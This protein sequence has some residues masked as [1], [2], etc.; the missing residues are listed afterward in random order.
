MNYNVLF[1]GCT[2]TLCYTCVAVSTRTVWLSLH[3][4]I[5][6]FYCCHNEA[7]NTCVTYID[8]SFYD[9]YCM[10]SYTC[11]CIKYTDIPRELSSDVL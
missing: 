3:V 8:A 10:V 11:N 2:T 4:P 5:L 9:C 7:I 1:Y 6:S